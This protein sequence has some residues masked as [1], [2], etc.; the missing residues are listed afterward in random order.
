MIGEMTGEPEDITLVRTSGKV[1][2]KMLK[3]LHDN[4]DVLALVQKV[5][6]NVYLQTVK[7]FRVVR[8]E[9]KGDE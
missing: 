5:D 3:G 1:L 2:R 7:K 8:I 6:R 9:W 4:D